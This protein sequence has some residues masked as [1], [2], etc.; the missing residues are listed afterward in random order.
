[1]PYKE[2][3]RAMI[4]LRVLIALVVLLCIYNL[5]LVTIPN[6]YALYRSS[7]IG[8]QLIFW[9]ASAFVKIIGIFVFL[10]ALDRFSMHTT[11]DEKHIQ[12]T[13]GTL[14]RVSP[15]KIPLERIQILRKASYRSWRKRIYRPKLCFE[16]KS[17]DFFVIRGTW[18]VLIETDERRLLIGSQHPDKFIAALRDAGVNTESAVACVE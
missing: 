1:M 10:W 12:V 7:N 14:F 5:V 8:G 11:V 13:F 17:Y 15:I 6:I 18:G 2:T 16:G 3:Q 4:W 9:L